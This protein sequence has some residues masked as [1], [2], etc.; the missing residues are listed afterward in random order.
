MEWRPAGWSV[1]L[2]P[3]IFPCTIKSR[4]SFLASPHLG[5]PGKRAVKRLWCGVVPVVIMLHSTVINTASVFRY[6]VHFV[7]RQAVLYDSHYRQHC[8]QRNAPVF[9]LL[10]G[11]FEVFRPAGATC[12]TNR[13]EIW[14]GRR[15]ISPPSVQW[16]GYRIP[17]TKIFTEM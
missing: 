10:R 4:N 7:Y 5:G 17:K 16:L 12:C 11:R 1:C 13:G 14:R 6:S 8:V 3:F 2:P 15:Q 9:K